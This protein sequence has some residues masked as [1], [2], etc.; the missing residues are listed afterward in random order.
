MRLIGWSAA[1]IVIGL[2]VAAHAQQHPGHQGTPTKE[3]QKSIRITMEALHRAGG[4]PPGWKFTLPPGNPT[5]GR[6]V[7][8]ELGCHSC[9]EVK[10]EQFPAPPGEKRDAG[11]E[12]T[13]MGAAHPAEF[14]AE[15]IVNPNA[16]IIDEPGFTG[17]DRRS[18][19]PTFNEDLTVA[20]L[21][22]LVAYLKSLTGGQHGAP[23]APAGTRPHGH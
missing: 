16:V 22:D 2:T 18:K 9:H 20:Q 3:S 21:I 19:M 1:S 7:F 12:L 23:K 15:A 10:G 5:A 13:G 8:I 6:K 4:V 14:L 17:P 11:P